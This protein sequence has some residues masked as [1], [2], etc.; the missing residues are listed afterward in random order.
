M[1]EAPIL[2]SFEIKGEEVIF[3]A[4]PPNLV[5]TLEIVILAV[6]TG[7]CVVFG[8]VGVTD[9][10]VLSIG[11]YLC[12]VCGALTGAT[13]AFRLSLWLIQYR[14][15]YELRLNLYSGLVT[16]LDIR[17]FDPARRATFSAEQVGAITL[18]E[19]RMSLTWAEESEPALAGKFVNELQKLAYLDA[20]L[21]SNEFFGSK[22]E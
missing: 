9:F 14:A 17:G 19:G 6:L 20:V 7:V 13:L 12:L 16:L 10:A 1:D 21:R 22:I 8:T 4:R 15:R 18:N 3:S 2:T 11:Q 5:S